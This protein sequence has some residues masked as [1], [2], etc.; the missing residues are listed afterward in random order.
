MRASR[1]RMI[2]GVA[3]TTTAATLLAPAAGWAVHTAGREPRASASAADATS[4]LN[5][6]LAD[7]RAS[8]SF[9]QVVR[10]FYGTHSGTL[11][12]DVA[13]TAGHQ[14]IT[15]SDGTRAQVEVLGRTAFISGNPYALRSYFKFPA[16]EATAIG[17][18]WVSIPSS[19]SAFSS[20]AYDV[21]VPTALTAV[22]PSGRLAEGPAATIGGQRVIPI[23]GNVPAIYGGG[24]GRD[25]LYVTAGSHPL[26][27]RAAIEASRPPYP[28][29]SVTATMGDWGERVAV[30][31]PTSPLPVAQ[32]PMIARQLARLAVPGARGYYTFTGPQ[33]LPATV[34]RP[35]GRACRPVVFSFRPQV[36][37]WVRS[38]AEQVIDAA[39][40][41]GIDVTFARSGGRSPARPLFYRDGQSSATVARV[42]ITVATSTPPRLPN[43]APQHSSIAWQMRTDHNR[44]TA[45]LTWIVATL[46]LRTLAGQPLSVRRSIRQLIAWTQ[47]IGRTSLTASGI[48]QDTGT[49]HFTPADIAAMLDMSGCAR[50]GTRVIGIAA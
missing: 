34:G 49:D 45:D 43:G 44:R 4:L 12:N 39:R 20:L 32:L 33:G 14:L 13:L 27:V 2:T 29:V 30:A 17:A 40:A 6:A 21:T 8:G 47:G 7:A 31:A 37:A 10:Q 19:S 46:E 11:D 38:Q 50:P 36:P 15:S 23:V 28:K 1:R 5:R 3:L 22:A 41:Q 48:Y 42:P 18:H 24:S 35:W 16:G 26:P 25:T 9:R